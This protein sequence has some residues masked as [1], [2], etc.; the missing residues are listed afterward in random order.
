MINGVVSKHQ[1]KWKEPQQDD[2]KDMACYIS[3]VLVAHLHQM[4]ALHPTIDKLANPSNPTGQNTGCRMSE[5]YDVRQGTWF[6]I[7]FTWH[8]PLL[9]SVLI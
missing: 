9:F 7:L 5:A 1:A 4:G 2:L 3:S 8:F 6:F